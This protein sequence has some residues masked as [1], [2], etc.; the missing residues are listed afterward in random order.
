MVK[1]WR[2][3]AAKAPIHALDLRLVDYWGPKIAAALASLVTDAQIRAAITA[4]RGLVPPTV[5]KAAADDARAKIAAQVADQLGA[6]ADSDEIEAVIRQVIADSWQAGGMA[7][8]RQL[9]VSVPG[10]DAWEPGDVDA[11]IQAADGGLADLLAQAGI[12]IKGI[13]GDALDGLGGAIADGLL[14]GDDVDTIAGS[15]SDWA[16]G[17]RAD[18]IA[19]T[20]VARSQDA[21][22][23]SVYQANGIDEFDIVLSDGACEEC[24]D[25]AADGPYPSGDSI[26]PVHPFCRCASSPRIPDDWTAP[27]VGSEPEQQ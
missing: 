24:E 25:A 21:A 7:A 9:G 5:A 18:R 14:N 19:A 3:G 2:D 8:N 27:D 4:A 13:V 6:V 20:E 11:A 15:L 1:S 17:F 22:T 12:G 23:Q 10:W 26:V 16:S